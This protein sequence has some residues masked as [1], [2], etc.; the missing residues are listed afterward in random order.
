MKKPSCFELLAPKIDSKVF[1]IQANTDKEMNE[2]V[3]AI[4]DQAS[5][6]SVSSPFGLQHTVHVDFTQD[7]ITGLPPEWQA[8]LNSNGFKPKEV[9]ENKPILA[10]I[11]Q[12]T[13]DQQKGLHQQI[14][15]PD[16]SK[17][18]K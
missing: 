10:N 4:K 9:E 3:Q 17:N 14:S 7:G 18:N 13:Q 1:Y 6:G 15:I 16:K 5:G 2:W 12:L 8:I 11:I